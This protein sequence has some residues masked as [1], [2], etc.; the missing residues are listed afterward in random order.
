MRTNIEIDDRLLEEA[1]KYTNV[2]TKRALIHEALKKLIENYK[3]ADLKVLQGKI[4][5]REGYDYKNLRKGS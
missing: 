3:R 4:K 2:K 1:F 5:F